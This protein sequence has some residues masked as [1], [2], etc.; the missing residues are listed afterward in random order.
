MYYRRKILLSLLE[1]FD[2]ELEKIRLQKQL[3][4]FTQKQET[5]VYD[6]VP[7]KFACFSFHANADLHTMIKYGHVSMQKKKWVRME[8]KS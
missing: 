6:F 8:E 2:N 5:P 1:V 7:Y 4:L 3:L